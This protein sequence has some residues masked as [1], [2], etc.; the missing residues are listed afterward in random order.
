MHRTKDTIGVAAA[1]ALNP[2]IE[3]FVAEDWLLDEDNIALTD[4]EGN[5]VLFQAE[6]PGV[7]Q[8]HYFFEKARGKEA[9]ELSRDVLELVFTTYGIQTIFGLTPVH[10]KGALWLSRH[11]GFKSY[12]QVQTPIGL[13]EK[14]ILTKEEYNGRTD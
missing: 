2:E 14:F 6:L 11:L 1:V 8:G 10:K 13:C 7:V 9:V 12:G 5:F 3:N 4:G